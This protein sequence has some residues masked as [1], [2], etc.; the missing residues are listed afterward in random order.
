MPTQ[1]E[2]NKAGYSNLAHAIHK[3]GGFRSV[4]EKL[5]LTYVIKQSGYWQDFTNF[6]R[7]LLTFME[8]KGIPGVMPTN[9][10]L[11]KANRN[12]IAN[13]IRKHG[14]HQSVAEHLALTY[15]RKRPNHW[16]DFANVKHE[17]LAFIEE[18][19][20]PRVMPTREELQQFGRGDLINAIAQYGGYLVVAQRLELEL[21]Y[22][23]KQ[24]D[25]W[26]DFNNLERELL[27][28]IEK[29]GTPGVMPKNEELTKA[30]NSSL[31][32][33]IQKH[34][35]FS[36]VARR[37]GLSFVGNERI[38]PRTASEIE[39][40]ARAIQPLAE[41][42]LLTGAQVMVILRRA[43]LLEYRNKRV[44]RLGASLARGNHDEIE[45]AI[46]QLASTSEEI[47]TETDNFEESENLT[48]EEAE[49][50]VNSGLEST[51]NP[52]LDKSTPEPDTQRE[53]AV[54]WGLTA[55][56]ESRL[57]LD[58]VLS[59][60]TSKLLWQA[61][62]KRLYSWYGGLD[63]AQNIT[64]EDVEAAILSTY[65]KHT[66]HKFVAEASARFT[67]EVEQAV[68]FAASLPN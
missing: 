64:A 6:E 10:E 59:L 24:P 56:G 7:E 2:L 43:G 12:D 27:A 44:V 61:F 67:L 22:Q 41:S 9:E 21:A 39:K 17:L 18:H 5:G 54:I 65:P 23:R 51:E 32:M 45:T 19:G 31:A 30:G 42:N 28:F 3:D 58:E 26:K 66:E 20:T 11:R 35:G 60:L 46:S 16:K 25:Y 68:N 53:Q 37:L 52:P 55:L 40:T 47:T 29:H 38:T 33:A 63:A 62:Y 13:A 57:P 48:A 49:A 36:V 14:G 8:E 15:T 34:G 50:L 1:G 4:A